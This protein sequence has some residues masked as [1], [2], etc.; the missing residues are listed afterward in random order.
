MKIY[1]FYNEDILFKY[2]AI[3]DCKIYYQKKINS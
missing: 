2:M 3:K 1:L